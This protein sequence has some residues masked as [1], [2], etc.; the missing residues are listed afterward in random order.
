M[1]IAYSLQPMAIVLD[2]TGALECHLVGPK[3][4]SKPIPVDSNPANLAREYPIKVAMAADRKL[5][6]TDLPAALRGMTTGP[7]L[8][9]LSQAR[10][11]KT[12]ESSYM[13][14][15]VNFPRGLR[16]SLAGR[17]TYLPRGN[18]SNL[19]NFRTTRCGSNCS[20]RSQSFLHPIQ[21]TAGGT[22]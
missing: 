17:S 7:R 10:T 21:R 5:T 13:Q 12:E 3:G 4:N 16:H 15:Y 19:Q 11:V 14:E 18:P 2:A 1:A 9:Q 22:R 6:V 20:D 8:K